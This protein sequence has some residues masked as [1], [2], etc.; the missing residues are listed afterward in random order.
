MKIITCCKLVTDE[1]DIVIQKDRSVDITSAG[2]KISQMDL[3]AIEAA[4][5]LVVGEQDIVIAL[6]AGGSLLSQTKLRKDLLSRGP[7][8]LYLVQGQRLEQLTPKET[9]QVLALA[10]NKIGYDLIL[11]GEGSDDMYAQQVGLLVGEILGL[12]AVNA[13]SG[14]SLNGDSVLVQRTLENEIEELRLSLPA[15]LSVT[16]DI[17][18][19]TL[20][21]MKAIL[22]AG[23]KPV[24]VWNE[25][26]IDWLPPS[27]PDI[28]TVNIR[29][30]AQTERK[31]IL[32]EGSLSDA[33]AVI[34]EHVCKSL[35]LYHDRS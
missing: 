14:I 20:P 34:T 27:V 9:A 7:D 18:V 15:V 25:T 21:T 31:R 13:V 32:L 19:P 6:S 30:L 5:L 11:F 35:D 23:K 24:V 10:A 26:D 12:P 2:A 1:Q 3:N 28:E 29:A 16:S 8:F 17:N 22:A 4:R 33:V